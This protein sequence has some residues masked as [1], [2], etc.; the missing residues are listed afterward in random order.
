MRA[1]EKEHPF[2]AG[3]FQGRAMF[4]MGV[5]DRLRVVRCADATK[6]R[7]VIALADLQTTVRLAAQRRLRKLGGCA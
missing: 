3:S 1:S 2:F 4:H 7:K 6:L 5:V